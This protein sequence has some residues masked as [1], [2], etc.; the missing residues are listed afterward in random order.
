MGHNASVIHSPAGRIP[1]LALALLLAGPAAFAQDAPPAGTSGSLGRFIGGALVGLGGHELGHLVFDVVFDADP[2]IEKVTFKGLPFFAIT[3]R[4]NVTPRQEYVIASAGFWMQHATSEWVLSA[5]PD[6]RQTSGSFRKGLLAFNVGASIV[7]ATAA[8][9][10]A[11]PAERDT[12]SM[13]QSLGIDE[14]WVGAMILAP[15]VLDVIRYF[16]PGADWAAWSSRGVK[17]GLVL[18]VLK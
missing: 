8:F 13:A 14:R 18:L 6:L 16:K 15:A 1:G 10:R 3:H 2:G 12:R 4:G 11:G 9:A 5:E 7:Y 17:I